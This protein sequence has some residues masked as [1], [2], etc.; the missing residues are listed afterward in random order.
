MCP[1]SFFA[2]RRV[3]WPVCPAK[4]DHTPSQ[5]VGVPLRHRVWAMVGGGREPF[6]KSSPL[7]LLRAFRWVTSCILI[8]HARLCLCEYACIIPLSVAVAL[9]ATNAL[10]GGFVSSITACISDKKPTWT[11][12][13]SCCWLCTREADVYGID[14]ERDFYRIPCVSI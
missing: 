8:V 2:D 3:L 1:I 6:T 4:C 10:M 7:P 5:A 14:S 12:F 13:S 11:F 9:R